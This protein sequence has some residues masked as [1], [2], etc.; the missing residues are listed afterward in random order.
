MS[1]SDYFSQLKNFT[2]SRN[3]LTHSSLFYKCS[4]TI[5]LEKGEKYDNKVLNFIILDKKIFLEINFYE[6]NERLKENNEGK[7]YREKKGFYKM[8]F[9]ITKVEYVP[10][11]IPRKYTFIHSYV[12]NF[13]KTIRLIVA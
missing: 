3:S 8:K 1:G 7:F 5:A 6:G 10:R 9:R 11:H 12:I 4:Q 13:S 2:P